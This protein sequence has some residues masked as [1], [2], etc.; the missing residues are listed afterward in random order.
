MAPYTNFRTVPATGSSKTEGD[1]STKDIRARQIDELVRQSETA[2]KEVYGVNHDEDVANFY[3]LFERTRRMPTF[4]PRIAAPQLQLLLLQEAAEATDTNMRVFIHKEEG[5]D[6]QREKAFQEHWKQEF[7]NLQLLMAQIY[8]QFSG[9][10]WLQV[11]NDP[12][13]KRG[14]GN[15]WL[16][17]RLP[18]N[19]H[20]DPISP[21]PE[22]WTWQVFEDFVYLDQI[23]KEMPDHAENV[24]RASAKSE[25]LAG[26]AAGS[27]EMPAGPMSVTM[28]GLPSGDSYSSDGPMKRR[29]CYSRDTTMR[30]LKR[31]EEREFIK[32]K[33]KVPDQ[34]PVYPLGR[35]TVECEGT[36]LV[37]G[38]SPLP[39]G[40]LWPAYP[41]WSVPPWDTVWCPAP[42]K[43]TKS[44]QDAAE[45]Q[46]TN[47]YENARRLNNGV[48]VIHAS[49]GITANTFGG[50]PGEIV[51]V[52]ANSP[53]G[54]GIDIKYP[55]PFAAQQMDYPMKLLA[56]Q[57]ELRGATPA[58]QGNMNPG[59]VGPDLFEAAVSQSQAGT[60]LTARLFA[61]TVQKIAELTFYTMA[62]SYTDE[63]V[64][65]D[66]D[67]VMK[68]EPDSAAEDYEVQVPEG[69]VRPM[70]Q[71]A[72][73]SMVIEL[74]KA[75]MIDT[76]HAL[77]M[78]DVPE[79]DEIADAIEKEMAL[80]ALAKGVKK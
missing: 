68:W 14:K 54:Q 31:E 16:R 4:R 69:A 32:H 73:R 21:W 65:R 64:Y 11:G 66:K 19:V 53:P 76:R 15:V 36:I 67:K 33:L 77:D 18:K 2:R 43:Y 35:M 57:K 30:D 41:V 74:K 24:K 1:A 78:L 71:S 39:L 29:F 34:L 79:A 80:A 46:M 62:K 3:N 9:T 27:L 38:H 17:A 25:N 75:A 60:R 48:V 10:A 70:S 63:R 28:R 52:G 40:D 42:M 12:F 45:Q 20:V 51:V 56:L 8:A 6:K 26:A 5:R 23:K 50:L 61:W 47:N 72:L 49:T 55:P 44:L 58:R 7:F 22:D 13:A 59:N 37:D